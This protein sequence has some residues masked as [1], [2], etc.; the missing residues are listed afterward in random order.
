MADR[1]KRIKV[2]AWGGK[3]DLTSVQVEGTSQLELSLA[4]SWS[5]DLFSG[6]SFVHEQEI[7]HGDIQVHRPWSSQL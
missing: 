4:V 3:I 1:L 2:R 5:K 6:L 7:V